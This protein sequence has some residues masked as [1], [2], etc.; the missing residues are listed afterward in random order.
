MRASRGSAE[1][2]I[3]LLTPMPP[4][5]SGFAATPVLLHAHLAAL[6]Q[7]H[8]VTLVTV[9]GPAPEDWTAADQLRASGLE[10]HA[11]RRVE[12]IRLA[13]A[14]RWVRHTARWALGRLPMRAIWFYRPEVQ[15]VID[16]LCA[17]RDFDLVHA[18]D[19]AMGMY[20]LPRGVPS[21]FTEHE[22]RAPRAVNWRAWRRE[23]LYRGLLDEM[24]WHR[25]RRYQRMTWSRFDVVQVLSE[26]DAR[27]VTVIAPELKARVRVNPFAV[28]VPSA[29]DPAREEENVIVFTGGFLHAP[30]VDAV[31]WLV[32]EIMPALRARRPGVRLRVFGSDPRGALRGL[33]RED[34]SIRGW[35][36]SIGAE[37]ERA[38]L[39]IAPLRIGGGQRMKVFEAMAAGKA[40]VTTPRGACGLLDEGDA[41][42]PLAIGSTAEEIATLAADLLADLE[43]R[44][45]LGARAR[46]AILANHD[47][48]AYDRRIEAAYQWLLERR[49]GA[50]SG[51]A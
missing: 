24:D 49:R 2:R 21:L 20:R 28:E 38:A 47:I 45:A 51:S 1:M 3:L 41:G 46:A 6:R 4:S 26:R 36:P 10:I 5:P 35:V 33:E 25:W 7:R 12:A 43:R 8:E 50:A 44:H 34:V 37:L 9:A 40:V 31:R 22:V 11:V 13:R 42:P 27:V 14:V 32:F 30:N 19:N 23:G 15:R 29:M 17:T 16:D 39:V 48:R 18:E